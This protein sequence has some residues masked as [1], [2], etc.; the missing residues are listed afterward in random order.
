MKNILLFFLLLIQF[1]LNS[2]DYYSTFKTNEKCYAN[3][4]KEKYIKGD[5][6]HPGF[7]KNWS[8]TIE[9]S[10]KKHDNFDNKKQYTLYLKNI[11]K[12]SFN[13]IKLKIKDI[14][15]KYTQGKSNLE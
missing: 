12:E 6:S 1:P 14:K 10:C 15:S 5:A 9:I 7:V 4:H 2:T 8:E 11:Y 13:W 3:I